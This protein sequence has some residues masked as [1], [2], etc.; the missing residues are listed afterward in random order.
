[1]ACSTTSA[2]TPKAFIG[3]RGVDPQSLSKTVRPGDNIYRNVN[4]GWLITA[5]APA[6]IPY[7]DD[8]VKVS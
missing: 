6:G 7:I 8:F 5:K 2:I 3:N 4:E 1:M